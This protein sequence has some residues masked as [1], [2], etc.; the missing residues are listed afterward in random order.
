MPKNFDKYPYRG[1]VEFIAFPISPAGTTLTRTLDHLSAAFSTVRSTAERARANKGATSPAT[2]HNARTH[3]YTLLK[4][5][6]DS[7]TD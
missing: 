7:L 3:N 2:D 5:L 1:R 6:L 4:S